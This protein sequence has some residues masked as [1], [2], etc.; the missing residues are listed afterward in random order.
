MHSQPTRHSI[1]GIHLLAFVV[2]TLVSTSGA[3]ATTFNV[4]AEYPSIQAGIDAAGGGDTVLV[5]PAYYGGEGNRDLHF[6]GPFPV[7]RSSGGAGVTTIDCGDGSG[8]PHHAFKISRFSSDTLLIEGFTI[9]NSHTSWAAGAISVSHSTVALRDCILHHNDTIGEGA[10][11]SI[12]SGD[13]TIEHC[14]FHHNSAD[15]YGGA[16]A[17]NGCAEV[18]IRESVFHDNEASKGGA[19]AVS[20]YRCWEDVR[21]EDCTFNNNHAASWG[22]G[23]LGAGFC[24]DFYNCRFSGNQASTGG[25]IYSSDGFHVFQTI[26]RDNHAGVGGAVYSLRDPNGGSSAGFSYCIF[27]D[28]EADNG[29]AALEA[30]AAYLSHCTISGNRDHGSPFSAGAVNL[31]SEYGVSINDCIIWGNDTKLDLWFYPG[32]DASFSYSD[33]GHGVRPGPGNIDQDPRLI[34]LHGFPGLLRP[35]SPCVDAGDKHERDAI[36]DQTPGWPEGYA[37]GARAD[38]GAYGGMGNGGWLP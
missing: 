26:F 37:N 35:D 12:T 3:R 30:D 38:M 33:I 17:V 32:T 7:V 36:Y 29:S 19:L 13:V 14:L 16:L 27:V 21:V 11:V 9:V 2:L 28:N 10:A 22:G 4:P 20:G 5:A 34:N 25:A 6:D 24:A 8:T 31:E 15:L 18:T 23:A 1:T